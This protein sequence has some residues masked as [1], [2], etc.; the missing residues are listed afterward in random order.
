MDNKKEPLN[1]LRIY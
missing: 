1:F